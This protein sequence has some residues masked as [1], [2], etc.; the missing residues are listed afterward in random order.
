MSDHEVILVDNNS[1][2][3]TVKRALNED[4]SI[5]VVEIDKFLPGLAINKGIRASNGDYLVILSAHCLPIN[6]DWL[7]SM[8]K[9]FKD[10][11]V[12]G[13]YGRQVPMSYTNSNDKRDLHITFGLD[14]R[15]QKKDYFFHNANSMVPR[16]IWEKHPFD[17]EVTNIEDRVWGKEIVQQGSYKIIY[18]P[19]APVS[20][21]HGIHHNHKKDRADNT[22]RIMESMEL[23]ANDYQKETVDI[24]AHKVC[25][26]IPLRNKDF[27]QDIS[28]NLLKRAIEHTLKSDYIDRVIVSTDDQKIADYAVSLGAEAPFIRPEYLSED[29]SRVDDVL[30][31]SLE[32]IEN[33]NYYPDLVIS[34]EITRPFRPDNLSDNLVKRILNQG[35]DTVIPGYAEYNIGWQK[36]DDQYMRIDQFNINKED[37]DPIHFGILGLGSITFPDVIRE[38]SRIGKNVGILEINEPLSNIEIKSTEQFSEFKEVLRNNG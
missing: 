30:K 3:S 13:V 8:Y 35:V 10:D 20:H 12:A 33:D 18:E 9:N 29:G 2:D 4:P 24:S 1:S 34:L 28:Q 17:E 11:S 38:G 32:Q 21:H 31:Y 14:R 7:E 36:V 6:D 37:R 19:E 5:K 15:E 23:I 26:I 25:A 27:S 16:H 22:L